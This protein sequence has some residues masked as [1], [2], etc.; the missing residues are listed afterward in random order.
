ML[1]VGAAHAQGPSAAWPSTTTKKTLYAKHDLRGKPGPKITA[2][3]W[4]NGAAPST[5]GKVVILDLWATWCP[6][7]RETIPELNALAAKFK[8]DVVVIG[9]SKENPEVVKGFMAKTKMAYPVAVDTKGRTSDAIGV[10]G[11]PHVLVMSPDGVV[12]WQGFP[13]DDAEPLTEATVA[14]IVKAS[15]KG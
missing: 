10:E 11:I 5:K 14:R 3:R 2:E 1:L 9:L 4:L 7:C 13:L 6:P 8:G 15:R 12:R